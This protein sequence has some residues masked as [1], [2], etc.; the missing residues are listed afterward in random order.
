MPRARAAD[1]VPLG[2]TLVGGSCAQFVGA[3]KDKADAL[4]SASD[5]TLRTAIRAAPAPD[6]SCCS[7][8]AAFVNGVRRRDAP[9]KVVAVA[10]GAGPVGAGRQAP[11]GGAGAQAP[12]VTGR[13]G[14]A[15]W[16]ARRSDQ[17][18]ACV[19]AELVQDRRPLW[20]TPGAPHVS[21]WA[22]RIS[23]WSAPR[24]G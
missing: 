12:G 4:A 1:C 18:R 17:T 8:A 21:T 3:F 13:S 6:A 9:V 10:G 19:H 11:G 22:L 7:D 20:A 16:T 2:S 15:A 23:G 24:P 5:A 14:A